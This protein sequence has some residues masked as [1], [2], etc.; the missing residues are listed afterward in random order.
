MDRLDEIRARCEATTPGQTHELKCWPEYFQAVKSGAK[1]F[2]VRK[3][4]RP[5][6]VGDALLLRE[7]EPKSGE[8][9]GDEITREV[10]YLLDLTYL[11]GGGNPHF[12]GYVVMGLADPRIEKLTADLAAMTAERDEYKA[13]AE[14]AERDLNSVMLGLRCKQPICD[15]CATREPGMSSCLNSECYPKWRGMEKRGR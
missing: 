3:W 7:Y 1:T 5:Y 12:A 11:P 15:V 10:T 8:Y 14:A 4:D 9:T 13:R 2:E 6:Q